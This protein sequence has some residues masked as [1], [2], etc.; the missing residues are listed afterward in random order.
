LKNDENSLSLFVEAFTVDYGSA[1]ILLCDVVDHIT[2]LSDE[3]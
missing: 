3:Q 1:K 2:M